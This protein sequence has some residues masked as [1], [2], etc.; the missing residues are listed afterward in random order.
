MWSHVANIGSK[1]VRKKDEN[2]YSLGSCNLVATKLNKQTQ[3]IMCYYLIG[4]ENKVN[5]KWWVGKE[6][7]FRQVLPLEG[8]VL[9]TDL[10]EVQMLVERRS[11]DEGCS[12][13]R[14]QKVESCSDGG[15]RTCSRNYQESI[16]AMVM[17]NR[18]K[19]RKHQKGNLEWEVKER[20]F[21]DPVAITRILILHWANGNPL[22][23]FENNQFDY[24]FASKTR[25]TAE[26]PP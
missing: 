22:E 11:K 26:W 15:Q 25:E 3:Y 17:K 10:K 19:D 2:P 5:T 12:R 9:T 23:C 14:E 13:Q 4:G 16:V 18:N 6:F 20:S 24:S 8:C 21:M 1:S 7:C